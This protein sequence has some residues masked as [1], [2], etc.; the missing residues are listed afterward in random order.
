L[1]IHIG[2]GINEIGRRT[3]ACK[4]ASKTSA[5]NALVFAIQS[6]CVRGAVVQLIQ[7][8]SPDKMR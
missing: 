3:A 4:P 1:F 2:S 8:I 5:V 7:D 6:G